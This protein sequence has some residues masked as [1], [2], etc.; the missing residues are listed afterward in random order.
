M[1]MRRIT[2]PSARVTATPA[3]RK[4]RVKPHMTR[5]ERLQVCYSTK[6]WRELREAFRQAGWSTCVGCRLAKADVLDHILPIQLRPDLAFDPRN[7][8]PLCTPCHV[9]KTRQVDAPNGDPSRYRHDLKHQADKRP[10]ALKI[11]SEA[12]APLVLRRVGSFA[13]GST[14]PSPLADWEP[15]W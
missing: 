15:Y 6:Q 13:A 11:W 4:P 14:I 1:G 2:S 8:Q 12:L 9:G 5:E 10:E 7:L 3:A